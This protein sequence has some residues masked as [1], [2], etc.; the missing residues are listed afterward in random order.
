MPSWWFWRGRESGE[1]VAEEEGANRRTDGNS[2]RERKTKG[3]AV[4]PAEKI[5]GEG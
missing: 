3:E 4:R 2:S 5:D 1:G